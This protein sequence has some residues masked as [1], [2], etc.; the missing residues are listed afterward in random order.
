MLKKLLFLII[1]IAPIAA[2]AQNVSIAYINTRE[3]ITAMPE[4]SDME[5]QLADK[6]EQL[7]ATLQVLQTDYNTKLEEFQALPE[8]TSETV[9]QDRIN[10]IMQLNERI[11]T[12]LQN[13]E[14]E[15]Q[16][17]EI[18]L[19]EPIHRRISEAIQA[20]SGEAGHT[21]VFDVASQGSPIVYVSDNAVDITQAVKTRLGL[22]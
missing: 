19:F 4:M 14:Q 21:F 2:V 12:F 20:V 1:A 3:I 6:H 22:R 16:M 7:R 13:S 5:R 9:R 18:S 10:Q 15:L 11:Q 8:T 17:L